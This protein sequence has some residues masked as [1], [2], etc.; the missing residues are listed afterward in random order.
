MLDKRVGVFF[1]LVFVVQF[2]CAAHWISGWNEDALDGTGADGKDVFMWNPVIGAG[3]NISDEIGVGGNSGTSGVYL[4]DCE[5]LGS[6]CDVGNILSLKII[7]GNYISWIVNVTVSGLGYDVPGNLSLN[8]PPSSDLIFPLDGGNV[9][10]DVDFNCSFFDYDYNLE[11][12]TLWGNWGGSWEEIEDKINGLEDG[13]VVFSKVLSQGWYKWNCFVE[14]GLGIGEFNEINHSFFVDT[15][16]PLVYGV[17]AEE[18]EVCG[19]SFI[20]VNCSASDVDLEI[21]SVIVQSIS[22][23]SDLVNYSASWISGDVYGASVLVDSKGDWS[24][25]CFAN[26]SVGN[27]NSSLSG[28]VDVASGK[29]ELSGV[30][31]LVY[32]D[33]VPVVEGDVINVSVNVSNEGCVSSGGFVVGFFDD[34]DNFDNVS[35]GSLGAYSS[36]NVSVLWYSNIGDSEILA[37]VDLGD[38]ADED[39]ESNNNA[40]DSLYLKAWQGIYGN[41]SL[42]KML[43]G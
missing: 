19:Y 27:L 15:T 40:S 23:S 3:D 12:V 4:M 38:V 28:L 11:S 36:V 1:V 16:S 29:P 8:S 25:E 13:S 2:G 34:G 39:N 14:D 10:G 26:D 31:G 37:W 42:D 9:S 22:P 30:G 17:V 43:R 21:D 18:S 5:M 6:G 20:D 35:V 41:M 32:F 33:G 7:A 24:F